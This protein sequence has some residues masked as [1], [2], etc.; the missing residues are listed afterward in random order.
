MLLKS[1]IAYTVHYT[2]KNLLLGDY[3]KPCNCSGN[4]NTKDPGS[5]DSI[6]GNCLKCVNNTAG[7]ACNLCA[8]GF[9]GDAIFSKNC[10]GNY[11][12]S[13]IYKSVLISFSKYKPIIKYSIN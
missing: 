1:F 7:A 10:T 9:F 13:T 8:P 2:L 12:F 11:S 3:C 4:I 5:C 6:T